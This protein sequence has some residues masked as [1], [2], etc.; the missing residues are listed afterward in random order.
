[1]SKTAREIEDLF[2][3]RADFNQFL[4]EYDEENARLCIETMGDAGE[5]LEAIK[6][7]QEFNRVFR[8]WDSEGKQREMDRE[9]EHGQWID[10][11]GAR[12]ND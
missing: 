7:H 1:M 8:D 4:S 9:I 10:E 3:V 6:M 12:F 2:A 11:Q 5:E